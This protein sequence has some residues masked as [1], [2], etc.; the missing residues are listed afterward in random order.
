MLVKSDASRT[1]VFLAEHTV[2]PG[3]AVPPHSHDHEDEVFYIL[4]GE[5][6]LVGAQGVLTA[7]AGDTAL[8]PRGAMHSFRNASAN[9][10]RFLVIAA[11]GTRAAAMF[12]ALDRLP[13][14]TPDTVGATCM[15][16]GV[17]FA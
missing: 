16:H 15:A 4:D 1:A 17:R 10:V 6:T 12:R 11:D 9:P 5:L 3:Y 14:P 8:L 13:A 2:P 7:R